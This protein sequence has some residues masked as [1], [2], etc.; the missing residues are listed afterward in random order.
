MDIVLAI[1]QQP[2]EHHLYSGTLDRFGLAEQTITRHDQP[3]NVLRER[4]R[5][6]ETR[7]G[8]RLA[9]LLRHRSLKT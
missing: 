1:P 2:S 8:T 4:E 5:Q 3:R 6:D 9:I 7:L